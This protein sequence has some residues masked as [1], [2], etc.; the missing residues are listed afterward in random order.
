MQSLRQEF[1][2]SLKTRGGP[3]NCSLA[4]VAQWIGC[5]LMNQKVASLIPSQGTCLGLGPGPQLEVCERQQI[6][7][8]LAH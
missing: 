6:H 7:V 5:R 2:L 8:S 3:V 1:K 4:G